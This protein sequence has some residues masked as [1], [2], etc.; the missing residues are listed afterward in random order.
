MR[1]LLLSGTLTLALFS[2]APSAWSAATGRGH[3]AAV[4]CGVE[5]WAVKTLS[6]R[7]ATRVDFRV[8]D[9]TITALRGLRAPSRLP[10]TRVPGAEFR[11]YR[12]HATLIAAKREADHDVHLVVADPSNVRRTMIVELPDVACRGPAS[13]GKKAQMQAARRAFERVCGVPSA[14]RFGAVIT[15]V[16]FFDFLHGQRGVAPNGIE[17]HPVLSFSSTNCR[18]A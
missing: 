6:D 16:G 13:S 18:R 3:E 2:A 8:R 12:I 14:T 4:S 11:T 5:R 10:S 9:T 15:G 7:D 17:L 1:R